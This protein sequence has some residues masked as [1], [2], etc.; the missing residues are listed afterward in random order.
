MCGF[1]FTGPEKLRSPFPG[2][3]VVASLSLGK[4]WLPFMVEFAAGLGVQP[5][6]ASSPV[7]VTARLGME[8]LPCWVQTGRGRVAGL[9]PSES[10]GTLARA[11]Q[12]GKSG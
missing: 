10:Q 7:S 12:A 2:C 8:I 6:G 5:R 4:E 3:A 9:V 1:V 11:Q